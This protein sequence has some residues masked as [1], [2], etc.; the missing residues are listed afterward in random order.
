MKGTFGSRQPIRKET[1]MTPKVINL[2]SFLHVRQKN[3]KQNYAQT[4]FMY[5]PF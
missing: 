5:V 2:C 1:K 4:L 3:A